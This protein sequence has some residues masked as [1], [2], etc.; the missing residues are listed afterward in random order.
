MLAQTL[1]LALLISVPVPHQGASGA[2]S[3]TVRKF[4]NCTAMQQVFP[5]GVARPGAINKGG[6]SRYAPKISAKLYNA[7]RSMDRD[8]DGIACER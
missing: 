8:K 1:A 4:A 5:G 3:P 6:S 2:A 7:N